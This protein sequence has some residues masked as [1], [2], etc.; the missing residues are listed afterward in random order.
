MARA[1]ELARRGGRTS[2]NPKVGAVAVA[3]GAI[4]GEGWHEGP[5]SRHAEVI[6]LGAGAQ[7]DTL[8]VTL[9]PCLHRGRTPPCAPALVEAGVRTVVV[10][11]PDP[12]PR[13]GGRGLEFLL[14]NGVEVRAGVLEPEAR[15]LNGAYLQQRSRGRPLVTLKLALT[16]DGRLAAPDGSARWI[17]SDRTRRRVHLRRAEVD[18]VMV[19]AGTVIADDP[20]L[21]A[22]DVEAK[23]QPARVIVD[24]RGKVAPNARVFEMQGEA[25]VATTDSS[26][27]D[28]QTEWKEAGAEVLVLPPQNEGVDLEAL[29][30]GLAARGWLE[31][32]CEGGA[33]LATSLLRR[34]LVDRLELHLGPVLVGE[35]GPAIGSL[36]ID[37]LDDAQRWRVQE[38][39]LEDGD[40]VVVLE[41]P[42]L[43]AL[44]NPGG[45]T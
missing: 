9:E 21:T 8:Y 18:A 31:V 35:G 40:V 33:A 17:T 5:G 41:S 32:Y 37:S 12:D 42:Q 24:A 11:T 13:V 15:R 27:H 43:E 45:K 28:R 25:I 34:G 36:G 29:L 3:G 14:R 39:E 38:A 6:A 20:A 7:P 1:L 4:V 26:S 23:G 16:L 19:G 10:A 44:L 22:R 30:S 2:P